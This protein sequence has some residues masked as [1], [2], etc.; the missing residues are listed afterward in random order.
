MSIACHGAGNA[1]SFSRDRQKPPIL[2]GA[3]SAAALV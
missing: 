3:N 1:A 2:T